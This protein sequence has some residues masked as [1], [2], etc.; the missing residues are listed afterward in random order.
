DKRSAETLDGRALRTRIVAIYL[1]LLAMN[2]TAWGIALATFSTVPALLALSWLAY[3]LGLRH[4]VD[5]DHIAAI[6]ST[7]RK[8]VQE[9][10]RPVA[11]GF[12][13]SLGHSTVVILVSLLIALGAGYIRKRF[14]ELQEAGDTFGKVI[15]SFFL[16]LIAVIN[17]VIFLQIYRTF[18]AFKS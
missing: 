7:T 18:R 2:V 17:L 4:A 6:D 14:P 9:N 3:A 5:A 15:S 11:V 13:F 16:F 12:F 10:K 1:L 8:L